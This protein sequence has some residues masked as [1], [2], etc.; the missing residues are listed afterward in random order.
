MYK[1]LFLVG[2]IL[3][4]LDSQSQ[5]KYLG[6][7]TSDGTPQNFAGRDAIPDKTFEKIKSAL[8]ESYPVPKY[9]PQYISSGYETD[10][11][12][13]DSAAVYIT[14]VGEGAGYKNTLGFYTY[15]LS[16]P[17][18]KKPKAE[19]IT[20]IF[21][22][23][24]QLGSGGSLVPGDKVLLGNF[25]ANTGIG[26]VLIADGWRNGTVTN[27]NWV[28]YSNPAFN[29]ESDPLLRQHNVVLFDSSLQQLILS[30]EDIRRDN[31]SCDQDFNDAIFYITANPFKAIQQNNYTPIEIANTEITSGNTGGL[32][33]NGRLASKI[34]LRSFKRDTKELEV[35]TER[36]SQP[37][38]IQSLVALTTSN[39]QG[40]TS[41]SL[42]SYFPVTGMTGNEVSRISTPSDLVNITNAREIFSLDYYLNNKR[43]AVG[44][45]SHTNDRVYDH[46]KVICDRL[47][48]SVLTEIRTI[49]LNK[50]SIINTTLIRANGETEYALHFSIKKESGNYRL[51][52]LW[53]IDAYP[54]GEYLNFQF[55]GSSMSEICSIA[56]D[57]LSSIAA[58][59]PIQHTPAETQIPKV[60]MKKGEYKNG[61]LY[62]TIANKVKATSMLFNANIARSE[63]APTELV[64]KN[65][66]LSGETEQTL[67]I[68]TGF[69]FDAG[70]SVAVPGLT[71]GDHFYLADGSWGVDYRAQDAAAV[72]FSVQPIQATETGEVLRMEREPMVKGSI[73]GVVNLFRNVRA[74]NLSIPIHE[75]NAISFELQSDKAVELVIVPDSLADWDNRPRYT[76]PPTNGMQKITVSLDKWKDKYGNTVRF[77]NI[78][79]IVFSL[80][81][82]DISYEPF[83]LK[84]ANTMFT[85][86]VM[87]STVSAEKRAVKIYPNPVVH[88]A[89]VEVPGYITKASIMVFDMAGRK[90]LQKDIV[91]FNGRYN[92]NVNSL[93][94]G[95]YKVAIVTDQQCLN[96]SMIVNK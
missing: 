7:Y 44:L 41:K 70:I 73:K 47:N 69:L 19:E 10:I 30:F 88:L 29:P 23:V 84:V 85:K 66:T 6:K 38:F 26:F 59:M 67:A 15:P 12:L 22:N 51:Y 46:S 92:L 86:L 33:S 1:F 5:Y 37:L 13:V 75:Y 83:M 32:E 89:T 71:M 54:P 62:L 72:I 90:C 53:N 81:G 11:R 74:G 76:I 80:K 48:G 25:P 35:K 60:F 87:N 68:E 9:N 64:T 82:N 96:S 40:T 95:F 57:V 2:F 3:M 28:L 65:I 39:G 21:P 61:K 8:P 36:N 17:I 20:I 55:W 45:A 43:V 52:S 63:N 34:A 14:F 27:G 16:E 78:R 94:S 49:V 77:Q 42:S 58:E 18:A 79:N 50:Y 4:V 93:P 24:S 31:S 56:Y 91:F